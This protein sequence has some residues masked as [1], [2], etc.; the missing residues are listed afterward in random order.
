VGESRLPAGPYPA[1]GIATLDRS[2]RVP[3]GEILEVKGALESYPGSVPGGVGEDMLT[4]PYVPFPLSLAS[5]S[6]RVS[7]RLLCQNGQNHARLSP[8]LSAP[9]L[10]QQTLGK[11][12]RNVK[13]GTAG[14]ERKGEV[15]ISSHPRLEQIL[16][17]TRE[18]LDFQDFTT[19]VLSY[20]C[21]GRYPLGG[22]GPAGNLLSPTIPAS[23]GSNNVPGYSSRS[24]QEVQALCLSLGYLAAAD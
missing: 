21:R 13:R 19:A 2:R 18:L 11:R 1:Q 9:A 22:Y 16:D 24:D 4:P 5:R 8:V 17:M 15:S 23:S 14:T 12:G 6:S 3:C 10:A 7:Q 20:S